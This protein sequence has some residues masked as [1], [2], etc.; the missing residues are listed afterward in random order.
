M[1][2]RVIVSAA[3][4]AVAFSLASGQAEVLA[5]AS[6]SAND[7]MA[8]IDDAPDANGEIDVATQ[9][10]IGDFEVQSAPIASRDSFDLDPGTPAVAVVPELSAWATTLLSFAGFA[11]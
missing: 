5:I 7:E 3:G 4:L 2:F 10:P 11:Q 8:A 9:A 6:T 1:R